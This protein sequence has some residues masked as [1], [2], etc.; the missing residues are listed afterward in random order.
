MN[1]RWK[2]L[3]IVV[4]VIALLVV[5]GGGVWLGVR[6]QSFPKSTSIT[7]IARVF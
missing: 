1:K 2:T 5:I 4:G 6:G 7:Q 3:A